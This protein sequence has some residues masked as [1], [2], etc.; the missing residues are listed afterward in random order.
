DVLVCV[1]LERSIDLIVSLVAIIKAG[2]AYVALDPT[3]PSERLSFMLRESRAPVILTTTA[4]EKIIEPLLA[5]AEGLSGQPTLIRLDTT[6]P[7]RSD[8]LAAKD[9]PRIGPD[10]LAY[11]SFTSGSTGKPK[12]VCV[13]HRG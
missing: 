12:G 7:T 10:H 8:A 6:W 5:S 1:C 3:C 11:V 9:A 4:G 2:G 13:P